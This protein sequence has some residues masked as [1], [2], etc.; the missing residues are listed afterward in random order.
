MATQTESKLEILT[1]GTGQPVAYST[2][3]DAWWVHGRIGGREFIQVGRGDQWHGVPSLTAEDR[4][5]RP[6][7]FPKREIDRVNA[8]CLAAVRVI[9]GM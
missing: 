6:I 7:R 9:E 2:R 8:A 3:H 1:V 5:G 4:L